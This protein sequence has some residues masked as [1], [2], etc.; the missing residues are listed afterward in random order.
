MFAATGRELQAA[1]L[2][3]IPE[4]LLA[5]AGHWHQDQMQRIMATGTQVLVPP[6]S[7]RRQDRVAA[8]HG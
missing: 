6:A 3:E 7:S 5:D 2:T 1:G 8:N 4:V